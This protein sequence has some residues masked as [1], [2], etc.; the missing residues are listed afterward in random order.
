MASKRTALMDIRL[1]CTQHSATELQAEKTAQK[2][3]VACATEKEW[4]PLAQDKTPDQ[5]LHACMAHNLARGKAQRSTLREIATA[6]KDLRLMT[7]DH[8]RPSQTRH[9]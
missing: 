3:V 4:T 7:S 6:L 1:L 5:A 2:H 9:P 8:L